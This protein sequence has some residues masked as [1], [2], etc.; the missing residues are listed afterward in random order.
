MPETPMPAVDPEYVVGVL[1]RSEIGKALW[2]A[3]QFEALAEVLV[4]RVDELETQRTPDPTPAA[5]PAPTEPAPTEPA[6]TEPTPPLPVAGRSGH[7]A[8][9]GADSG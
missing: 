1:C 5:N 3:A 7:H 6:P 9:D 8:H 4:S 2:R